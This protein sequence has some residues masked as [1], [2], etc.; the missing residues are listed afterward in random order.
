MT[1]GT[2]S[3]APDA[4]FASTPVASGLWRAVVTIA[5]D[6]EGGG[7][8]QNGADIVRVGDLI[9]YQYD[10]VGFEFGHSGSGEGVGLRQQALMDGVRPKAG[11]DDVRTDQFGFDRE[12]GTIIG[13]GARRVLRCQQAAN[14]ARGI[15]ECRL[16]RVPAVKHGRPIDRMCGGR[17]ELGARGDR[18]LV[19]IPAHAGLGLP[20]FSGSSAPIPTRSPHLQTVKEGGCMLH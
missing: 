4:D 7:R 15:F 8:A 13:E 10:A 14:A 17:A 5:L 11:V 1:R 20:G 6:G 16:D 2:S 19:T 9:E 18:S 3:R 12:R